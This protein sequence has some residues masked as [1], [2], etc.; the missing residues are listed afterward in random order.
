[1]FKGQVRK[2]RVTMFFSDVQV[3]SSFAVSGYTAER[4]V[5]SCL[6]RDFSTGDG[7]PAA[8]EIPK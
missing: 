1:M 7:A 2:A 8:G 5:N 3:I 4:I 6:S